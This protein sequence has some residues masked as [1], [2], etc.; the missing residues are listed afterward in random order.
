MNTMKWLVKR[1]FWEHK[2]MLLWAPLAI[3]AVMILFSVIMM[4]KGHDVGL[5]MEGP[6]GEFTSTTVTI[7]DA[8]SRKMVELS[9]VGFPAI[10]AP[11]Y[12][13]M[14]FLVFFYSLGALYDE[15]K[16]RSLLFWKSLP[17]SDATTVLSKAGMALIVV[18]L[19]V[20]AAAY[21]T[22]LVILLAVYA[23]LAFKGANLFGALFATP[24]F[25]LTPIRM[26]SLL[27][28]YLLW[29]LPTVGWLLLVSSW[30]RSKVFLWAVGAPLL[31]LA[32]LAWA[33]KAF[34]LGVDIKWFVKHVVFRMLGS[35]M[36]G[37]WFFGS[38]TAR[39]AM[40]TAGH[41]AREQ[42]PLLMFNEFYLQSWQSVL[43]TDVLVGAAAGAAMIAGAVW[44]RRWREEG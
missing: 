16:D 3:G 27:P 17:V 14:A 36:P 8:Q 41:V 23:T 21:V 25:W 20:L 18:P 26:L 6:D 30:A 31:V 7:A 39:E 19:V 34:A 32:L 38:E 43:S 11:L 15:R 44:L 12:I 10:A 4:A 28:V 42:G 24:Q 22:S 13:S 33:E 37:T 2:G 9:A 5:H 35:T 29:A 1:E 40:Q